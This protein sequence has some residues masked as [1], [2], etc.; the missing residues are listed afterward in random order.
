MLFFLVLSGY[1][2]IPGIY[3][4]DLL[5]IIAVLIQV[6]LIIAKLEHPREVLAIIIFHIFAM[7]MEIFKTSPAVGSWTYPE[8]AILAI[9]SVPLFSGFMYSA[10]GSYIARAWRIN[11]FT[12]HRLPSGPVL[13]LLSIAI[14][15][16]F[17][18]N[19]FITDLRWPIFVLLVIAFWRTKFHVR[20]TDRVI[21]IHPL[22][23]N[24]F[25][26]LFIWLA[27]QISTFAR[28]WLYP[29]QAVAWTFV[30]FHK[31]TSWYMLL[32]F[33]FVI[34]ALLQ[35]RNNREIQVSSSI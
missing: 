5:F 9:A 3:R 17:F 6:A 1:V 29:N 14:Y 23:S 12:F 15:I 26:A 33:S 24:A 30:S 31:F 32:I 16:N 22:I 35:P 34:I 11:E 27:E 2:N 28:V 7:A 18:A 10:V 19:H 4:Y 13:V 8:P 20:I 21:S 25:L